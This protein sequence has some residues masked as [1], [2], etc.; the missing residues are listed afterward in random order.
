[1]RVIVFPFVVSIFVC[2]WGLSV[3]TV[4]HRLL[5]SE[6]PMFLPILCHIFFGNSLSHFC[7]KIKLYVKYK[8]TKNPVS[9]WTWYD[10]FHLYQLI[11]SI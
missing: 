9:Y 2:Q 1:M 3:L 5:L 8:N 7:K 4:D 11:L 6:G 10:S